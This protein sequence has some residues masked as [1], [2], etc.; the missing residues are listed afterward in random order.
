MSASGMA[1]KECPV[2]TSLSSSRYSFSPS[3][4]APTFIPISTVYIHFN[5]PIIHDDLEASYSLPSR[6]AVVS[7]A[8]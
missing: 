3:L 7:A 5:M 6:G 4:P 2:A 8:L 1:V